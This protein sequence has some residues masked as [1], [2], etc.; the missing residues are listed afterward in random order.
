[1]SVPLKFHRLAA[2][3]PPMEG[4]EFEELVA[5]IKANGLREKIDLYQGKIVDGRNRYRALQQ[6]GID[7]SADSTKYFRKAIYAH[8]T[9]GEIAPHE[10]NNDDSVRA[11]VI[12]KNI[13]RRH[14][15]ADQKRELIGKVIAAQ[16]EKSD[17]QIAKQVK[18]D[19]KTVGAI[20]RAKESTG[21]V[22]P[23]EKRV[24]A[25]GRARKQPAAKSES[26]TEQPCRKTRLE[27]QLDAD[28]FNRLRD[29]QTHN[30]DLAEKLRAAEIKIAGLESEV[31]ELKAEN[32][33]LRAELEAKQETATEKQ[34]E[35]MTRKRGRGRPKGSKNKPKPP[36]A[37]A[38]VATPDAAAA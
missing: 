30:E 35:A 15:T 38:V 8:T 37:E 16:P 5:D 34:G 18:A 20:R 6:L 10:R 32:A 17:R 21:E 36:P 7:P 27:R 22:S 13:H 3:F 23:V 33:R 1:M 28:A 29:E 11:Y 31:E 25:D 9:G 12:S 14:L 19:H 2:I 4:A 24:G 26:E